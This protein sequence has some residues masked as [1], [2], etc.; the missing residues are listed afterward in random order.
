M[1]EVAGDAAVEAVEVGD[2]G[3]RQAAVGEAVEELLELGPR[4][5]AAVDE[6]H[7]GVGAPAR[8][9]ALPAPGHQAAEGGLGDRGIGPRGRE[10]R[11]AQ[12]RGGGVE[13]GGEDPVPRGAV[14][15]GQALEGL[16]DHLEGLGGER[17]AGAG[18]GAAAS[19]SSGGRS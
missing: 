18:A 12:G 14:E 8:P 19:A 2:V 16:G 1:G 11:G 13:G 15:P 4:R 9:G 7:Q 17:Q 5:P 3:E 6:A 10:V